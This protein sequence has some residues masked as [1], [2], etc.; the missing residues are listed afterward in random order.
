MFL[1]SD[2]VVL[3]LDLSKADNIYQE[4]LDSINALFFSLEIQEDL[5]LDIREFFFETYNTR[6][7]IEEL[8]SFF[9]MIKPSLQV[10]VQNFIYYTSLREN[11]LIDKMMFSRIEDVEVK[12]KFNPFAMFSPA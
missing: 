4:K 1:L 11:K 8:N 5:S 6:E 12:S 10:D 2:V 3:L 9:S 7:S